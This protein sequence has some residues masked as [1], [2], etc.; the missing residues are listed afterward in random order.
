M[1]CRTRGKR[2]DERA[3]ALEAVIRKW[4]GR[5]AIKRPQTGAPWEIPPCGESMIVRDPLR[6]TMVNSPKRLGPQRLPLVTLRH[7]SSPCP[8]ACSTSRPHVSVVQTFRGE[9]S[10]FYARSEPPAQV[11][12]EAS[13]NQTIHRVAED[14]ARRAFK[15]GEAP[16]HSIPC[17]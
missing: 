9:L 13:P 7:R 12:D 5:P 3:T 14:D 10:R 2:L 8:I 1:G 11:V 4:R 17:S 16:E 6:T 15:A